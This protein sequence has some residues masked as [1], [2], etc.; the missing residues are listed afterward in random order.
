MTG[1]RDGLQTEPLEL[2]LDQLLRTQ[3]SADPIRCPVYQGPADRAKLIEAVE[4]I[5]IIQH[6]H[7]HPQ[8]AKVFNG[9]THQVFGHQYISRVENGRLVLA[10]TTSI[11]DT[12]YE[13]EVAYTKQPF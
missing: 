6:S 12:F 8:G 1:T 10:H 7:A 5:S 3:V 2:V 9:K 4:S 11:A 13:D